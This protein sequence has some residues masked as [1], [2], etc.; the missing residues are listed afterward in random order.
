MLDD[1]WRDDLM[2]DDLFPDDVVTDVDGAMARA[3][4]ASIGARGVSSPNPPVGAVILDA[5]GA[6]VG[7]GHTSAPGGAH[8]EVNAL[9]QAGSRAAGGTAVVTLEPCNH[10]G[11]TGPCSEALIAAGVRAVAYAVADPNPLATGGHRRLEEAGLLVQGG[12]GADEVR[13]GPLREWLFRQEHGRP[14]VTAKFA[15]S[16]DGRIAAPDGTSQWI[17]GD[18]ARERVH[19]E[20]AQLDAII[21]GTGTVLADDPTLTAR[22]PDG[23]LRRH[24]PLRVVVGLTDISP[25]ARIL[26]SDAGTLQVRDRDPNR[27]LQALGD[28]TN[29]QIEGGARLLGAFFAAGLVDRVQAYIAPLVIGGG[30]AAVV[31][32]TVQT[33]TQGHRFVTQSAETLGDD[34]LLTL[35]ATR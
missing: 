22:Y 28:A 9:A 14:M 17:T 18:A 13:T 31:D 19:S 21:V 10:T 32:D 24:Q 12:V 27:V 8:A 35:T 23:S 11:R 25:Q 33:L 20:R 7:I 16:V 4:S 1:V 6:V 34:V 5:D 30:A 26:N 15:A 29:V 2:P 3:L